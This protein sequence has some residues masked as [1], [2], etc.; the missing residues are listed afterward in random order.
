MSKAAARRLALMALVC[1]P[2][3]AVGGCAAL[4]KL[5]APKLSVISMKMQSGDIFSQRLLV[6]MRVFNPNTR[7]LPIKGIT[8][9]I[10]VNDAELGKGG[11]DDAIHRAGHG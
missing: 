6:R 5:E 7:E 8:Y 11:T 3:L 4:P 2:L 1:L 10:E 9:R